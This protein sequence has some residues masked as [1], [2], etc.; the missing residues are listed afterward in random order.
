MINQRPIIEEKNYSA[1]ML[2]YQRKDIINKF[3]KFKINNNLL[4]QID[5]EK[6]DFFIKKNAY[7][8]KYLNFFYSL[9]DILE[10]QKHDDDN[11]LDDIGNGKGKGKGKRTRKLQ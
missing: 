8:K 1:Y 7:E 2:I 9:I 5:Q 10:N 4:K 3:H 11:K 6:K